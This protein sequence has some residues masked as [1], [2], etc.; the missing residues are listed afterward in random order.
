MKWY[1]FIVLPLTFAAG[2]AACFFW[3]EIPE[4]LVTDNVPTIG[5]MGCSNTSQAVAGY[6]LVGGTQI[7]D[8][9]EGHMHDFDGGA[10]DD[11]V[12]DIE[13]ESRFWPK[14]EEYLAANPNTKTIWWQ[15]CVRHT[16]TPTLQDA[17]QVVAAAQERIPGV[18]VY[19]SSLPSYV[20]NVCEITGV[21]GIERG[22][23]LAEQLAAAS[24]VVEVGPQFVPHEKHELEKDGCHL[25][26]VGILK[27]GEQ[28][29]AFFINSSRS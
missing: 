18:K 6:R 8:I 26:P 12:R 25:N 28:L 3:P 14:F 2:F 11:W 16:D 13:S 29:Q 21:E 24:D 1:W 23:V 27:L 22:K 15:M 5:Y 9:P 19:V 20:N 10:V 4:P 7:W 17:L